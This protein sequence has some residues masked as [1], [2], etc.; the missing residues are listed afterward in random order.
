MTEEKPETPTARRQRAHDDL[1]E[2]L[3]DLLA[4]E[5]AAL[6]SDNPYEARRLFGA[7]LVFLQM[8]IGFDVLESLAPKIISDSPQEMRKALINIL[9]LLWPIW[10][11]ASRTTQ[12]PFS[13]SIWPK[14]LIL[15]LERFDGGE[16]MPIF[17]APKRPGKQSWTERRFH[18]L[19][20]LWANHLEHCEGYNAAEAN[21][22]VARAFN[23]AISKDT[24]MSQ[25]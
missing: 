21:N 4:G 9:Y 14:D 16:T 24:R 15:A 22:L 5:E 17:E 18:F 1:D 11:G 23:P 20:V 19:A 6:A 12:G 8:L 3:D 25:H 13:E 2:Y 7:G 10:P